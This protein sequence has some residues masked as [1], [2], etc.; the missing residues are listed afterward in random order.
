MEDTMGFTALAVGKGQHG[1]LRAL[2]EFLHDDLVAAVAEFFVGH[3]GFHGG[4]GLGK[5]LRYDDA[6]AQRQSVGLDD[7]GHGRGL[8]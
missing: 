1:H 5:V 6:L 4:S 3:D 2:Q 7:G 8:R